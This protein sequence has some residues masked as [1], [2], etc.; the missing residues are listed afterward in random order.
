M[1]WTKLGLLYRPDSVH[2]K[3]A[4]HAANPLALP[5]EGDVFRIFF[6]GRDAAKRSSVG[7]VDV[8]IVRREVVAIHDKPAF[9]HGPAGSYY[10]DGVSIGCCYEVGGERFMLFMGWSVPPDCHWHGEVGRLTVRTDYALAIK[11]RI[12]L[13][14]LSAEDDLSVSYPWVTHD[15]DGIY[16][17]WYGSTVTWD[18]GNGEMLHV[19]KHATS[20]D[21]QSWDLHGCAVPHEI[22]VAQA[23]S[24]PTIARLASGQEHMWFSYRSGT[25]ETYRIGMASNIAGDWKLEL[26][27]AN[28]TV[29][30]FGWD[31]EMV[32]YPFVFEHGGK[33]WMLYNGNGFGKSGFGI[34]VLEY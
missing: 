23:F 20:Q 31:S 8:D 33:V 3:L 14:G 12:A 16:R 1:R 22:N 28:L 4:S 32:C 18:A 25:G 29:S 11:D 10:A 6:S 7:C 24:R 13:I 5:L 15:G 21:G 9:E 26:D 34:A 27:R 19:I 17:M 2:P 30:D